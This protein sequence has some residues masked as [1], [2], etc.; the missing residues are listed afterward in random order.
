MELDREVLRQ[1]RDDMNEA[2]AEVGKRHGLLIQCGGG[3]TFNSAAATLK[4]EVV[5]PASNMN[6][7]EHAKAVADWN[8][9]CTRFGFEREWLG[10]TFTYGVERWVVLGLRPT[11]HKHPVLAKNSR[12]SVKVL[13]ASSLLTAKAMGQFGSA[14]AAKPKGEFVFELDGYTMYPE[15]NKVTKTRHGIRSVCMVYRGDKRVAK[16]DDIP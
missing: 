3:G 1:V 10:K 12:G 16:L 11:R 15:R 9:L 2:L 6:G 5:V 13:P 4:V 14:P 8:S 7:G